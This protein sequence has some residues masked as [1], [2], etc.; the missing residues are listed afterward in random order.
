MSRF[1]IAF[2]GIVYLSIALEQYLKGNTGT[3]IT[4]FGYAIGN[5]G[6]FM[7]SS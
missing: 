2:I 1:L 4:F 7:V 6:L 3:A 5:V